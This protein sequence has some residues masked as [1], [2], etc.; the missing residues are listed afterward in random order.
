MDSSDSMDLEVPASFDGPLPP[1][2]LVLPS[3]SLA[4]GGSTFNVVYV[5]APTDWDSDLDDEGT[6]PVSIFGLGLGW[7]R[8]WTCGSRRTRRAR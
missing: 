2:S 8:C 1:A 6:L 4:S 5:N 3:L 7:G